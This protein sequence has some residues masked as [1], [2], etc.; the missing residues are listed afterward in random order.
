MKDYFFG[1]AAISFLLLAMSSCSPVIYATVGQNTPMFQQEGEAFLN[2][3]GALSVGPAEETEALG[4]EIQGGVAVTKTIG[5]AGQFCHLRE[6][7]DY[8][9]YGELSVGRFWKATKGNWFPEVYLGAGF[10]TI[11]ND[12]YQPIKFVQPFVQPAMCYRAN[13]FEF[14][15]SSRLG[16][17]HY[18]ENSYTNKTPLTFEPAITL[19]Q[20][21]SNFKF[22][23]QTVLS[24][25][26]VPSDAYIIKDGYYEEYFVSNNF[27][28]SFS[29]QFRIPSPKSVVK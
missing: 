9:N 6:D 10:G 14:S 7:K 15:V 17:V 22:Q 21:W 27:Y 26:R 3:G 11:N 29:L 28:T 2:V 1:L 13:K 19:R 16:L 8:G 24:T 5:L 12:G 4:V 25:F 20:G 18:R 23:W